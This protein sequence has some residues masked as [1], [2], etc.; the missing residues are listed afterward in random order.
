MTRENGKEVS[1]KKI[2]EE[3][4]GE[5]VDE[6]VV[7]GTKEVVLGQGTAT[8]YGGVPPLTAAHNTLP[9]GTKVRVTA[10]N[11]GK[12]VVVKI[13]DR[14]IQGSAIID[15]SKDSFAQ[16]APLGAGVISVKLTQE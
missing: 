1:R 7:V 12:S 8:W 13:S 4:V 3:V 16:I 2:K 6:I 10:L 5:P 11:T 14:G 15:L 9:F